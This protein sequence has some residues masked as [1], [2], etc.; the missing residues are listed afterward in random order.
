MQDF[1]E[2]FR[3][4]DSGGASVNSNGF[5]DGTVAAGFD[6]NWNTAADMQ[7]LGDNFGAAK[8][9]TINVNGQA[10]QLVPM[11]GYTQLGVNA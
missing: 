10:K 11:Q 5:N 3:K 7:A 1:S 8:L 2:R 6:G 9:P 4:R